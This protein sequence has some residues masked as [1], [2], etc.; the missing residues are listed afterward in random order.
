MPY[1][2]K[3]R[4]LNFN[5]IHSIQSHGLYHNKNEILICWPT[6]Q[7]SLHDICGFKITPL[8]FK[9]FPLFNTLILLNSTHTPHKP[10]RLCVCPLLCNL[11]HVLA[12]LKV[13]KKKKRER[14][15]TRR[16]IRYISAAAS[17]LHQIQPDPL[18]DVRLT[19][20]IRPRQD[21]RMDVSFFPTPQAGPSPTCLLCRKTRGKDKDMSGADRLLEPQSPSLFA[22]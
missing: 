7:I 2:D 13:K 19:E 22:S 5:M 17:S 21:I 9:Y 4:H 12:M 3:L 1:Q 10:R 18:I 11:L 15:R 20:S 14:E 6:F 8:F 16:N